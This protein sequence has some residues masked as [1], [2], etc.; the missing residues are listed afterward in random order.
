MEPSGPV[1]ACNGI[2]LRFHCQYGRAARKVTVS[3]CIDVLLFQQ[4]AIQ[5]TLTP[6]VVNSGGFQDE[7]VSGMSI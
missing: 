4:R 6:C 5:L 1:Q 3:V 7:K 2:A